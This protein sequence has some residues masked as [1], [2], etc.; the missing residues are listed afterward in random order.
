MIGGISTNVAPLASLRVDATAV[1]PAPGLRP[2]PASAYDRVQR[3]DEPHVIDDGSRKPAAIAA[4]GGR[5]PGGPPEQSGGARDLDAE[6]V[7]AL[8][9]LRARDREV[10]AHE[11]AHKSA[12]GGLAAGAPSFQYTQGPDGRR[13]AVGG[14]VQIDT[15]P[16][17][18]D[19]RATIAKAQQIRRAAL[20]PAQPS[21]T[22]RKVAAQAT[23]MEQQARAELVQQGSEQGS[24]ATPGRE[25]RAA[26]DATAVCG[27]CGGNHSGQDHSDMNQRQ[28]VSAIASATF[29][30]PATGRST[31]VDSY[32]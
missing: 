24:E 28:L 22:D 3:A 21:A 5:L 10:R 1:H 6:Q 23:A 8:Q 16:I 4:E 18:G 13:Y 27:V 29:A 15:A 17:P 12:A 19:P 11:Q 20:A 2:G 31:G 30:E 25:S 14:E 7:R 26:S 32:A 9:Q